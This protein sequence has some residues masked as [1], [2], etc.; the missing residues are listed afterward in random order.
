MIDFN[1]TRMTRI[2]WVQ[3]DFFSIIDNA[4]VEFIPDKPEFGG[5]HNLGQYSLHEPQIV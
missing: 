1:G 4:F 3:A 2:S 5:R